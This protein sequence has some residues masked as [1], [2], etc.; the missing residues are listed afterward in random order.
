MARSL[1]N[2][3]GFAFS[4]IEAEAFLMG[5]KA[6]PVKP[7]KKA[8]ARIAR[9]LIRDK[10]T[11]TDLEVM[12][13]LRDLGPNTDDHIVLTKVCAINALYSTQIWD[14]RSMA[15]SIVR[16]NIDRHLQ[17]GDARAVTEIMCIEVRG[18]R[19]RT[20]YSFATKFCSAHNP[21]EFPIFDKYVKRALVYYKSESGFSQF[22]QKQIL[23]YKNFLSV[24]QDFRKEY[25]LEESSTLEVDKFLWKQ[26][27]DLIQGK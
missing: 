13:F 27:R 18:G 2:P 24:I 20:N 25:D 9:Q 6:M 23:D 21:D 3:V 12:S 1:R 16:A 19:K 7:T 8:V 26:G 15:K 5:V 22:T 4:D 10:A 11:S 14:V 17:E